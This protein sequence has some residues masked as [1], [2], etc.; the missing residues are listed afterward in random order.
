MSA[1]KNQSAMKVLIFAHVPPPHHGQSYMVQ[2][3][4]N[5][6]GGDC[7]KNPLAVGASL[8]Q[9]ECYHVNARVSKNLEDIGD[10]RF[11][12][13]FLMLGYCAQAIWCRYR[14]GV[15]NFYFIPAPG[16]SLALYRDWLV[17]FVCRPFFKR[18]ILHWHAAGLAK[19]LETSVRIRWR[20]ITYRALKA[21]DLC[22]VLSNYNRADAEKLLPQRIRIVS[23]GILD[24]CPDFDTDLLPRRRLRRELRAKILAGQKPA[25][26]EI[27][28][29]GGDPCVFDALYLAHCMK[30]KGLFDSIAGVQLANQKLAAQSSPVRIRLNV[31]GNFVTAAE[32]S[33]FDQLCANA[34]LAPSIRYL[35]FVGGEKKTNALREADL[36]CFPTFY[37]NENQ[38]VNLIEAM[39]VG[40]P[41]VTTRWRSLPEMF[42]AN[43]PGLVDTHSPAQIADA[44]LHL[45]TSEVGDDFRKVFLKNYTLESYLAGLAAAFRSIE[46]AVVEIPATHAIQPQSSHQR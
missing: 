18:L 5:G 40:L 16:K 46:T 6:F 35:G 25:E 1:P 39:A 30:E 33:E 11:G 32:K 24:P 26:E 21:A 3:M 9:I 10:M 8:H 29:A 4:L 31:A 19:W 45:I 20:A 23:N 12:K 14:Y 28:R 2:L 38:P 27:A 7:R 42:Q 15:E 43:Y 37:Q 13:I 41:I 17:M 36:F 22:V 44:L 34:E